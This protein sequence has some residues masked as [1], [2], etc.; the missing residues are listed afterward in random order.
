MAILKALPGSAKINGEPVKDN[1][2]IKGKLIRVKKSV[3]NIGKFLD[4]SQEITKKQN[5]EFRKREQ[6]FNRKEREEKLEEPK[7]EWKK[8]VPKK[9]P[10]LSF[11]DSIKKFVAGWILG[12]IAIKLIPLLPKL[13]PIVID[14]GRFV[15]FVIDVGGKFLS[16]FI[17]FI[18]FGV[19]AGEATFGFLKNIGGEDFAKSFARFGGLL[20]T[21]LDLMLLI[22]G[23]TLMERLSGDDGGGGLFDLFGRKSTKTA[24]KTGVK[25]AGRSAITKLGRNALVKTLGK[26]GSKQFLKITKNFISPV[27]KKIPLIGALADFA[28]NVF[29]FGESPGRAAFKAIGAGLGMWA[30]GALG[31]IV[32][33]LGTLIGATVGGIAGDL[34]G[35]MIYDMVFENKDNSNK[36]AYNKDEK[37]DS[38]TRAVIATGATITAGTAAYKSLKKQTTKKVVQEG[39]EKV[40]KEGGERVLKSGTKKVL[41][42]AAKASLKSSKNLISP[43]VKKIPFIGALVDFALNYFV[44]KEP[45][46]K[47]AF[48]AIGAGLGTWVGGALGTLIPVPGVGT[49]IGAFVGGVGGD[50]LGGMIYDMIFGGKEGGEPVSES[51]ETR[52]ESVNA[53]LKGGKVTSGNMSQSDA[54]KLKRQLE[55]E[56]AEDRAISIYGFNSP[57]YNEV[58]KQKLILSGT[59]A[60][61]IYT[62]EKGEVK[63]RGYSTVDGETK[64]FDSKKN[65]SGGGFKRAVGGFAD[66]ATL[67]MFD[68]DKQNRKGAPKD[69]GIRR[70]IGGLADNATFGL[71]DFDKRGAGLMQFNPIG[72]GKD[73]AWGAADEQAKRREKQ[74]GF[75][76]KRAIGGLLDFATFGMFDFDKQNRKGAPKGFGIKRIAGGLADFVTGGAT[77]FDKRGTGIG[78]M[79]LGEKMSKKRAYENNARVRNFRNKSSLSTGSSEYYP[80][81]Q[82]RANNYAEMQEYYKNN[83]EVAKGG[84]W[85]S[86]G[87]QWVLLTP[88]QSKERKDK[89]VKAAEGGDKYAESLLNFDDPSWRENLTKDN[90][91]GSGDLKLGK[92]PVKFNEEL[93]G[94][95][96]SY[97]TNGGQK[98]YTIYAPTTQ[99]NMLPGNNST[100]VVVRGTSATSGDDAY[101]ILE[102]GG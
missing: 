9:I 102:K 76:L 44:F 17:S 20:G 100:A 32:P 10:G 101:E 79:N 98:E 40:L 30:L 90:L 61:A 50:M 64:I 88:E 55:L 41:K 53:T 8:L 73:K 24:A 12:F 56:K 80:I 65:V 91:K 47:S 19:K 51:S 3:I 67:G 27:V 54:E 11:F 13:I 38:R 15:N 49:A 60:E 37:E 22:G 26:S 71:T 86:A 16:G 34:L 74:S 82:P 62:D 97:E 2:P 63:V 78:Q 89:L 5:E 7:K 46:G 92:Q 85:V 59:P 87:D 35:G 66:Y 29:V 21:V 96:A 93:L 31:S 70:I 48:M 95:S 45:L 75:G 81:D 68:F 77:D 25:S 69:F 14:L 72:G 58:Q 83:P 18:D 84:E 42:S 39:G 33:G 36:K 1:Q 23:M 4:K 52:T 57:E 94:V 99:I 43:I 6:N 28:L